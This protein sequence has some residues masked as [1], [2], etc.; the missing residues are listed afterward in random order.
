MASASTPSA[1]E[2]AKDLILVH[3]VELKPMIKSHFSVRML[4]SS[5]SDAAF[6]SVYFEKTRLKKLMIMTIIITTSNRKKTFTSKMKRGDLGT[7]D[8]FSKK[9][10]NKGRAFNT[11]TPKVKSRCLSVSD[12]ISLHHSLQN[13]HQYFTFLWLNLGIGH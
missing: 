4:S 12:A 5:I 7:V 10:G 6:A 9:Y 11:C 13:H 1:N 2:P 8:R 3:S